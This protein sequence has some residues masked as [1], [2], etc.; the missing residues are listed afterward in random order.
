MSLEGFRE[1]FWRFIILVP[2]YTFSHHI[3]GR[4]NHIWAV[5]TLIILQNI[6]S[7]QHRDDYAREL[8]V[9]TERG[10]NRG[11]FVYINGIISTVLSVLSI[12]PVHL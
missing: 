4:N 5:V 8:F 2:Y 12:G 7:E 9:E 3:F 10:I 11:T 6:I 1:S